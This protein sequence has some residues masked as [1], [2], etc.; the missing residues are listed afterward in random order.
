MLALTR[1]KDQKIIIG[2]DI[3][4]V[5]LEIK[6][7]KVK[8]GIKAPKSVSVHRLEVF[9]AIQDENKRA[10]ALGDQSQLINLLKGLG[11]KKVE[12]S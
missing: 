5:V 8:L 1:K 11:L 12:K 2:D 9:E 6:D 3:E 10:A 4:I 7:D